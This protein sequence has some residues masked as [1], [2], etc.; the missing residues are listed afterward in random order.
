MF[1]ALK[2]LSGGSGKEKEKNGEKPHRKRVL[3]EK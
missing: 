3:D 2:C 1:A